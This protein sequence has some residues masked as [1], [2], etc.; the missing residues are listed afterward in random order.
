[1]VGQDMPSSL[2]LVADCR[3]VCSNPGTVF[4]CLRYLSPSYRIVEVF[5]VFWIQV[6]IVYMV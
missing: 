2:H 6:C 5:Y 3:N 4:V 1:M